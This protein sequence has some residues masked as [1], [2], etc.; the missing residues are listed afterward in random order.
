M[1][2]NNQQ[3]PQI[4]K[5]FCTRF[6][7]LMG[8]AITDSIVTYPLYASLIILQNNPHLPITQACKNH[9]KTGIYYGHLDF[10]KFR[11][12]CRISA[13]SSFQLMQAYKLEN[14]LMNNSIC[15]AISGITET[16]VTNQNNAKNRLTVLNLPHS[17]KVINNM[18]FSTL[19]KNS[20]TYI[21]LFNMRAIM[22]PQISNNYNISLDNAYAITSAATIMGMQPITATLDTIGTIQL[23]IAHKNPAN[24]FLKNF[25]I[26]LKMAINTPVMQS[27]NIM[28]F[29]SICMG[30]SYFIMDKASSYFVNQ[31][32]TFYSN[33]PCERNSKV[34]AASER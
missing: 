9:L 12:L 23:K 21:T 11:L 10:L 24:S 15:G 8:A 22:G 14:N 31:S 3:A 30:A 25:H 29:R 6:L 16:L 26:A 32:L 34:A 17:Q 1:N 2:N 33:S 7:P 27:A 4:N 19:I 5:L 20:F 18:L 13:F 28:L